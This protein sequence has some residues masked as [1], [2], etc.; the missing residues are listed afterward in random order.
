MTSSQPGGTTSPSIA[1]AVAYRNGRTTQV[2]PAAFTTNVA[3]VVNIYALT[4]YDGVLGTNFFDAPAGFAVASRHSRITE[5]FTPGGPTPLPPPPS[6]TGMAYPSLS[7]Y[8]SLGLYPSNTV[9]SGD[10][11]GDGGGGGGGDGTGG[12]IVLPGALAPLIFESGS[13]ILCDEKGQAVAELEVAHTIRWETN[14]AISVKFE[15]GFDENGSTELLNL[16]VYTTPR[17][18]VWRNRKLIMQ[19]YWSPQQ[20]QLDGS[21]SD[22]MTCEFRSPFS[23]LETRYLD[24]EQNALGMLFNNTDSG[25]IAWDLIDA[26]N[27]DA[28]TGLAAGVFTPSVRIDRSYS[29]GQQIA[30]AVTDITDNVKGAFNFTESAVAPGSSKL[31][32]FD[33]WGAGFGRD[34]SQTAKFEYGPGTFDN[35]SNMQRTV[36]LPINRVIATGASTS[37]GQNVLISRMPDPTKTSFNDPDLQAAYD[38]QRTFGLYVATVDFPNTADQTQLDNLAAKVLQPTPIIDVTFE[39]AIQTCPL[40]LDDYFLGDTVSF[41]CKQDNLDFRVTPQVTAIEIDRDGDGQELAHRVEFGVV[42]GATP[43]VPEYA[44]G[45]FALRALRRTGGKAAAYR[46]AHPGIIKHYE[47]VERTRRRPHYRSSWP[48]PTGKNIPWWAMSSAQRTAQRKAKN[49]KN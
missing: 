12:G 3:T 18:Q 35:V 27:Q 40:P 22:S 33:I 11:G 19:G 43:L 38:S 23:R 24:L 14:R 36:N 25:G 31:M 20:D 44:K 42:A 45:R 39:P 21:S 47:W 34:L 6:T 9:S 4:A 46:K 1:T 5:V 28:E 16:L 26:A 41:I 48:A 30:E 13:L 29:P 37:V 15:L 2:N 8:P 17:L 7:T 32:A 49:P 10:G